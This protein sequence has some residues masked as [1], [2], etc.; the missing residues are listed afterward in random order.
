MPSRVDL[1][2]D[3][4]PIH[5]EG[6]GLKPALGLVGWP[7]GVLGAFAGTALVAAG[8]SFALEILG[9]LVAGCCGLI[10]VALL[11]C[12]RFEI[13]LG[14]RMLMVAA[15]PIR[16]R[17]PVGYIET[18]EIRRASSWRRLYADRELALGLRVGTESV[19]FPSEEPEELIRAV[20]SEQAERGK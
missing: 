7:L 4:L 18:M 3:E 15:G 19:V 17:V 8:S 13:V 20:E 5:F 16:R 12:R 1:E 9:V 11:R 2:K 10:L 14:T 6:L